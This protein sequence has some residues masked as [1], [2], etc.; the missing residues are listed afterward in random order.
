MNELITGGLA[1]SL[2]HQHLTSA[3]PDAPVVPHVERRAPTAG[4]RHRLAQDLRSV[5]RWV[6]PA[7]RRTATCQ[8]G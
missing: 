8:P 1:I 6:E 5:A 3:R 7:E 2:T 4:L